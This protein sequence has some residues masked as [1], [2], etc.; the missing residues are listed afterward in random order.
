MSL[1]LWQRGC[2]RL[3]AE[4]ARTAI[5]HLD[6]PAAAAQLSGRADGGADEAVAQRARA[7]P[8]QA[9][10]DPRRSTPRRIENM[11]S[12]AGRPAGAA[13]TAAV[14]RAPKR[15]ARP[16]SD[17]WPTARLR[18]CPRALLHMP[19]RP[20]HRAHARA[21]RLRRGPRRND[22]CGPAT[23]RGLPGAG[24]G[25]HG[26]HAAWSS[27]AGGHPR[28]QAQ[29]P[30]SPSTPWCRAA[31]TRWRAPPRCTWPARRASM[32]NPLFIYGGVGLGKTH[33]VARRGQRAADGPSPT[34]ACSTCTPSSSSATW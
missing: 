30:R 2:E 17:H 22:G 24:A 29:H 25:P 21:C 27:T 28:P 10:L 1:D 9:R 23:V 19:R 20:W 16:V 15:Q 34:P 3:A 33:L 26:A 8:I 18:A 12:R 31:P 14:P 13:G 32:Y 5:Q 6:P 4:T 7:Q 11:L